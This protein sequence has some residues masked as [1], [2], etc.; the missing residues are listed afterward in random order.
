MLSAQA[1]RVALGDHDDSA[2]KAA[3]QAE[4]IEPL[5]PVSAGR[6]LPLSHGI[7]L[8]NDNDDHHGGAQTT[9][10]WW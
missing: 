3:R 9:E 10:C 1:C 8:Y 5:L 7:H 2:L 6:S 4:V